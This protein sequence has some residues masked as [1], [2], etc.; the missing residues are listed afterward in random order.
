[1]TS[2]MM[3][4][5]LMNGAMNGPTSASAPE[6]RPSHANH[7]RALFDRD[8]EIFG[9]A[10]R[11]LGEAETVAELAKRTEVAV[12]VVRGSD[13]GNGH[14]SANLERAQRSHRLEQSRRIFRLRAALLFLTTDVDL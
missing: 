14:E 7:R 13:R 2:R 8:L 6:D 9:H 10:H 1:M 3:R 11:Q 4:T 5:A 12:R